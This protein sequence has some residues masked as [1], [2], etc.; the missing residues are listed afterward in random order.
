MTRRHTKPA[1]K[2]RKSHS[3]HY[4][5][6]SRRLRGGDDGG[7]S[8]DEIAQQFGL[9]KTSYRD[10][11]DTIDGEYEE[12]KDHID[13]C[14][15]FKGTLPKDAFF[16]GEGSDGTTVVLV[17]KSASKPLLREIENMKQPLKVHQSNKDLVFTFTDDWD[18]AVDT[19]LTTSRSF[20][21]MSKVKIDGVVYRISFVLDGAYSEEHGYNKNRAGSW[22]EGA[23][24]VEYRPEW[25]SQYQRRMSKV[26]PTAT[27]ALRQAGLVDDVVGIIEDNVKKGYGK[28][29]RFPS[30][31]IANSALYMP[32]GDLEKQ[33]KMNAVTQAQIDDAKEQYEEYA[34]QG[35][36]DYYQSENQGD[37]DAPDSPYPDYDYDYGY[38]D[39][40][41]GGR[42]AHRRRATRSKPKRVTRK[43]GKRHPK[44]KTRHARK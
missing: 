1:R 20:S 15:H 9:V 23:G 41:Y 27:E 3:K 34:G 38:D 35:D 18:H 8:V 43:G 28:P 37:Y 30:V 5:K 11:T 32:K 39:E 44:R 4:A 21:V 14:C 25:E 17:G 19:G 13:D 26:I 24:E 42:K 31:K 12:I 16:M 22:N 36:G 33:L 29:E 2:S 10:I 7:H 40:Y 6:S